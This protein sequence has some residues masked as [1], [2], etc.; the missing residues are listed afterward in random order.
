MPFGKGKVEEPVEI[1]DPTAWMLENSVSDFLLMPGAVTY[2]C[3]FG[4]TFLHGCKVFKALP[5]NVSVSYKFVSL[6]LACTGGGILVPI[7]LNGI[8][9]P[10][11]N[12]AYPIA[13]ITSFALHHYF[14]VLR[15]VVALSSIVKVIFVIMYE[16]T[17][18]SVVVK[19]T[20]LAGSKIAPSVFAFPVFGPIFCG[21]IAGCGGA[22]LPF[23]KGLD[24][25]KNGMVPPVQ[26]AFVGALCF[27]LFMNTSMSEG[28][29]DAKKKAQVYMALFFIGA[30]IVNAMGL[31]SEK[32]VVKTKKE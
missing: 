21:T 10:L 27:H 14:P 26:T 16:T 23:T 28:C 30:G 17:R 20:Y 12:D 18:A 32:T 8:P 11:A 7:F 5:A 4:Y 2:M 25:I 29:I 22:F 1:M 3:M 9:V 31:A 19:L 15:E 24:P 6:L 13:I